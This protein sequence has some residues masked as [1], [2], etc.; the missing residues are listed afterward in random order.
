[1]KPQYFSG[2]L[3][4]MFFFAPLLSCSTGG[5]ETT[6]AAD[7]DF[8]P[9]T[10]SVS[11]PIPAD[12][13][14]ADS[15]LADTNRR[16][17]FLTWDDAPQPPG[18]GNCLRTFNELGIKATFFVVGF[19]GR[20]RTRERLMDSLRE[21][22][23]N[24][25]IANHSFSHAMNN[26]YQRFYAPASLDSAVKD[27]EHNEK[28]L[29]VPVKILRFPGYNTWAVNGM[30]AGQL[31]KKP[32]VYR[33]DSLGYQVIGWD[34]EWRGSRRT[35]LP[36]E[37]ATEMAQRVFHLLNT[38]KTRVPGTIV[39]LSHDHFFGEP[40]A[41]DSL[42]TFIQLLQADPRNVFETIDRYPELHRVRRLRTSTNQGN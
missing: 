31:T 14:P 1:M 39:I 40:A 13:I 8:S 2:Y 15:I 38:G 24:I 6:S 29:Q 41:V 4:L 23:P 12:S 19:N 35:H 22:Y 30:I 21:S 32:L 26:R 10:D 42:R 37:S 20:E 16:Y 28:L 33:M 25:L 18:T 9:K 17:I 36:K 11:H 3:L 27:F 7:K 5:G 34:A